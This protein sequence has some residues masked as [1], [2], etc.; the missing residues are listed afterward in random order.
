MSY[1]KTVPLNLLA[2]EHDDDDD[3][4][5]DDGDGGGDDEVVRHLLISGSAGVECLPPPT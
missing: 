4:D 1:G 5:N 3:D 2:C